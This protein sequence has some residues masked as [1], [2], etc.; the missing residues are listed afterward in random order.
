MDQ[1]QKIDL[2]HVIKVLNEN[3][4]L[5]NKHKTDNCMLPHWLDM[6]IIC[7]HTKFAI[8]KITELLDESN[9]E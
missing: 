9:K 1:Y 3:I 2:K 5:Y 6:S 8:K 4:D 7:G